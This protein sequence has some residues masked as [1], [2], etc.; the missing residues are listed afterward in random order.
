MG[1]WDTSCEHCGTQSP[2][3]FLVGEKSKQKSR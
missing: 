2:N 3:V 1:P